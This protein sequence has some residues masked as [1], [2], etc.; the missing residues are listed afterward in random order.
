MDDFR[1][2]L[3]PEED[4]SYVPFRFD[5]STT[6]LESFISAASFALDH[7]YRTALI[8]TRA[9]KLEGGSSGIG[10]AVSFKDLVIL[11]YRKTAGWVEFQIELLREITRVDA[12]G[13]EAMA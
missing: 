12:A 2:T 3:A 9:I 8:N 7:L 11:L 1:E 13:M 4:V 6:D 10:F 5:Q